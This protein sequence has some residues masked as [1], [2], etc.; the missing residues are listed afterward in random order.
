MSGHNSSVT[1]QLQGM[2]R[3][4]APSSSS[5]QKK[6]MS[7]AAASTK[8]LYD[9]AENNLHNVT[10]LLMGRGL[11]RMLRVATALCGPIERWNKLCE[12]HTA[13]D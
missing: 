7:Q 9:K 1:L 2:H 11:M 5:T 6:T 12:G 10:I 8:Q 13:V 4:D 3:V